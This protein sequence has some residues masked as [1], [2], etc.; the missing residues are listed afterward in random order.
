MADQHKI[1]TLMSYAGSVGVNRTSEGHITQYASEVKDDVGFCSDETKSICI[2]TGS[3]RTIGKEIHGDM[4]LQLNNTTVKLESDI[5]V[6][7]GAI[8]INSWTRHTWYPPLGC[9]EETR[10]DCLRLLALSPLH[11][12]SYTDNKSR[13]EL[14]FLSPCFSNSNPNSYPNP[15][16]VTNSY[17]NPDSY[18]ATNAIKKL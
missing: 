11:S 1:S 10:R 7:K 5:Y 8:D 2:D 13:L 18:R 15:K 4:T 9:A 12:V 16:S 6:D 14:V 17:R 3:V